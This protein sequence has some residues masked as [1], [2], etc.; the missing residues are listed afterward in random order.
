MLTTVLEA[1][2][3]PTDE[4]QK[5][6]TGILAPFSPRPRGT[7][8]SL[9]WNAAELAASSLSLLHLSTTEGDIDLLTEVPGVGGYDATRAASVV[10]SAGGTPIRVLSLDALIESKRAAGRPRD[11]AVLQELEAIRSIR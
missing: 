10:V 3:A 9:V 8:G 2:Y 7:S 11:L 6:L 4:N 1:C 5:T